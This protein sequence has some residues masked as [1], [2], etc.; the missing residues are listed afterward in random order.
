M[1]F[2]HPR[3]L[4]E[5]RRLCDEHGALLIFDEIAAGFYRTGP[6]WAQDHA[7]VS[8]DVM[9]IGKALT[10]GHVTMAATVASEKVAD[11]ISSGNP[12]AFMHGP[13]YMANPLACSAAIASL[14][15]FEGGGYAERVKRIEGELREGLSPLEGAPN[16]KDVRV[17]GSAGVVEAASFA[18]GHFESHRRVRR[19][20]EAVFELHLRDAAPRLRFRRYFSHNRCDARDGALPPGAG[21]SFRFP[22]IECG[23]SDFTPC[24]VYKGAHSEHPV[25]ERVRKW[26]RGGE[27]PQLRNFPPQA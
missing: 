13:T 21:G 22:R 20:A 14:E 6:L 2:Y 12:P 18:R 4:R 26:P 11:A 27:A 23:L 3:Y 1:N 19:V 5:M 7:Q 8:P 24:S 25:K 17:L 10:G 16:V 15:L 9:C